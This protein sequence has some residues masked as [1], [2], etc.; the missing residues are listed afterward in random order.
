MSGKLILITG[1]SGHVGFR[2]LVE[3]LVRGYRVRAVVRREDQKNQIINAPSVQ[4]L[5]NKLE[6]VVIEDLSKNRAFDGTLE[7]VEAIIHVASPLPFETTDYKTD[8]IDPVVKRTVEVLEAA[9][10]AKTVKRVLTTSSASVL[11]SWEYMMSEDVSKVFTAN[12]VHDPPPSTSDFE[13]PFQAYAAAK[14]HALAVTRRF[15][16]EREPHFDVINILPTMVIGKNELNRSK[17]EVTQGTNSTFLG[18]LLGI[19]STMPQPGASVHVNDVARAHIDA[20]NPSISGNQNLVCSSGGIDGTAWDNSKDIV[21]R[22]YKKE[23]WE[24]FFTL[25]GT[26]PTRPIRID[27]SETERLLGWKFVGYEEQV[28][29]VVDHYIELAGTE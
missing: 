2:V 16:E 18:S 7:G 15:I 11:A 26:T 13:N 21:K 9:A 20:L 22:L 12:D 5:S 19:R 10:R 28:K 4:P 8:V 24:R 14:S 29:S 3:A 25:D 6:F 17:K 23:V 27:Y 1:V